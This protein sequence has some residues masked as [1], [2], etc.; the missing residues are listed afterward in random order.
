[1]LGEP[2]E[3]AGVFEWAFGSSNPAGE[4]RA[5]AGQF[6]YDGVGGDPDFDAKVA[7]PAYSKKHPSVLFDQAHKNLHTTGGSYNPFVALIR[8]DGYAAMP[9]LRFAHRARLLAKHEILVCVDAIRSL[10]AEQSAAHFCRVRGSG[11]LG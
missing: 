6:G 5:I 8:A 1:M 7:A 4:M 3:V 11:R 9:S 2:F 10:N